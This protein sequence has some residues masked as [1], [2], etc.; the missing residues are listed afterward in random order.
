MRYLLVL[1]LLACSAAHAATIRIIPP[2]EYLEGDPIP[3]GTAFQF[4]LYGAKCGTE[5]KLLSTFTA[6]EYQR[7]PVGTGRH[8]YKTTAAIIDSNGV[9]GP[10]S[11]MSDG[12]ELTVAAPEPEPEKPLARETKPPTDAVFE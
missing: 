4:K 7:N 10:E 1:A 9:P 5:L 12:Y 2:T 6:L 3:A 11:A 8:C